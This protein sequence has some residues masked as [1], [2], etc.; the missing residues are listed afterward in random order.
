M[1]VLIVGGNSNLGRV[2]KNKLEKYYETIS[3]G[4]KNCDFF[5][6]LNDSENKI[7]FP[8]DVEVV[9][10]C[11]AHFGGTSDT[12]ILEAES[13]NVLGT[14]K[15]CQAAVRHRVKHFVFISSIF[16][17]VE[18]NS[19][20]KNIYTITKR[21]AEEMITF[22]MSKQE[23]SFTI[24]RPS[25]FYGDTDAYRLHQPFFYYILDKVEKEEEVVFFG[26]NDA[27]RNFIHVEDVASIILK[28]IQTNTNGIFACQQLNDVRYSEVAYAAIKAFSS[29]SIIRF[30]Y[31]KPNIPD[32]IGPIDIS[33]YK[34]IG[35][36]PAINIGEGIKRIA[37]YRKQHS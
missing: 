23:I 28:V 27:L 8:D 14:L 9:I 10:H 32:N 7:I 16:T 4:R 2:L 12:E 37:T 3:T 11:A 24:L 33:L 29:S 34:T 1:K 15:L 36:Y 20:N 13:V 21:H 35:Y 5:L 22:Y 19:K 18:E 25:Q 30:D 17:Q 31:S 6:D 26:S